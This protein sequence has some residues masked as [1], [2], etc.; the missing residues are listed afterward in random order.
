[1]QKPRDLSELLGKIKFADG[2]NYKSLRIYRDK[3][4]EQYWSNCKNAE[5]SAVSLASSTIALNMDDIR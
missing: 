1:M 5:N 3:K 2:Y 4:I